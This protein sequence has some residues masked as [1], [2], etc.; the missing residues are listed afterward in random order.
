[1]STQFN[2]TNY[3][4]RAELLARLISMVDSQS[5]SGDFDPNL[6]E[7]V[8]NDGEIYWSKAD[9]EKALTTHPHK[10]D[11]DTRKM[12]RPGTLLEI[13]KKGTVQAMLDRLPMPYLK[14]RNIYW[15]MDDF[16]KTFG[17]LISAVED[18]DIYE[19]KPL[20]FPGVRPIDTL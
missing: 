20:Y 4:S 7:T 15:P 12:M 18:W 3:Y 17:A 5:W 14:E 9:V 6:I 1:M 10:V 8:V 11:I 16:V 2:S 13:F 19:A